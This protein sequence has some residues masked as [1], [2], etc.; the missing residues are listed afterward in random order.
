MLEQELMGLQGLRELE[1]HQEPELSPW[2]SRGLL[3]SYSALALTQ[4]SLP[5]LQTCFWCCVSGQAASSLTV[6]AALA[7]HSGACHWQMSLCV[8]VPNSK[9]EYLRG[10]L[11]LFPCLQAPVDPGHPQR[12]PLGTCL[13]RRC[14]DSTSDWLNHKRPVIWT[15]GQV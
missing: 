11:G 8:L 15:H 5:S 1:S 6:P 9:W 14:S 12:H 13:K 2:S 4:P 7:L 3:A 10:S